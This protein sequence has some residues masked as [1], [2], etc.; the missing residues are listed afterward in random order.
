MNQQPSTLRDLAPW[1]VLLV[2]AVLGVFAK[3][4]GADP[5]VFQLLS[6]IAGV[7]GGALLPNRKGDAKPEGVQP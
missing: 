1:F 7:A 6:T 3:T 4:V 2:V 5:S